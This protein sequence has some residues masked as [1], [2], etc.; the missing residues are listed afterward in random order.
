MSRIATPASIEAAPAAARPALE[1]VKKQ[2]GSVPNLFRVVANSPAALEGYLGL[3][4]A[5]AKGRLDGKRVLSA[6]AA[7][8]MGTSMTGEM[9]AGFAPGAG[10]GLGYEVIREARG[11][12]RYNSLGTLVKGGAYRTYEFI[13]PA[14][15]L[16]GIILLQ[17]T[18]GGGDVADEINTFVAMAA[19]AIGK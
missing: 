15:D 13:D 7:E 4:A 9:K 2:L 5:L 19:A 6:A 18:N 3:N 16:V 17:R 14:K 1:A 12:Y 11:T 8:M 10:H